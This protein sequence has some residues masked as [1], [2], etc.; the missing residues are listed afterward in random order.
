MSSRSLL[1]TSIRLST[2]SRTGLRLTPLIASP[3]SRV[4]I[5]DPWNGLV[6]PCTHAGLRSHCLLWFLSSAAWRSSPLSIG[7]V[8][9]VSPLV[10]KVLIWDSG[11]DWTCSDP[12]TAN[13]RRRSLSTHWTVWWSNTTSWLPNRY[14]LKPFQVGIYHWHLHRL[15]AVNCCRNSQLVVDEDELKSVTCEKKEDILITRA[16]PW[17]FSF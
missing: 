8:F 3:S 11:H 2:Y 12:K 6:N 1:T 7:R 10:N 9:G 17:K 13:T 14:A 4:W 5:P 16:V 15:Q